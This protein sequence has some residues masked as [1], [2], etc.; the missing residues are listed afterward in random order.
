MADRNVRV[1][2]G[3]GLQPIPFWDC[4]FES[5]RRHGCL[6]VCCECCVLLVRGLYIGLITRLQESYGLLF[7][8]DVVSKSRKVRS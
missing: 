2:K 5:R 4:R 1:V 7:D 6:S 3:V 8:G